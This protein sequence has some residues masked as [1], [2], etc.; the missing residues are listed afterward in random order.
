[1]NFN[2][3][4]YGNAVT[5]LREE[6][7]ISAQMAKIGQMIFLVAY[8]FGSELWADS[9]CSKSNLWGHYSRSFSGRPLIRWRISHSR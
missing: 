6:F 8:G 1:M 3:S 7:G 2:A 5:G 4:I 9:L